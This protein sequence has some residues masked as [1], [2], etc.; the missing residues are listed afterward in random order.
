MPCI[1][2]LADAM[3]PFISSLASAARIEQLQTITSLNHG[4]EAWMKF[5]LGAWLI[6]NYHLKPHKDIGFEYKAK[7]EDDAEGTDRTHKQC[8]L[9]IRADDETES[10]HYIEL[11]H[12]ST[13]YQK[14]V[15]TQAGWDF[16][17]MSH[18]DK[19]Y[20]AAKTGNLLLFGFGFEHQDEWIAQTRKPFLE[21]AE[22]EEHVRPRDH[23]W[24]QNDDE[25]GFMNWELWQHI[26]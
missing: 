24:L 10:Y 2:S 7:L 23:G 21:A 22:L 26:A 16:W 4:F 11:K 25:K 5:E 3:R 15:L 9:W 12:Y 13:S 1:R 20:E 19:Y 17:Y 6:R 8:D 18:I 14:K